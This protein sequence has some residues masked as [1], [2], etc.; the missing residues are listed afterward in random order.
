[1]NGVDENLTFK[2]YFTTLF[3][4]VSHKFIYIKENKTYVE[5]ESCIGYCQDKDM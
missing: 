4:N 3:Q 1:M 5:F 2:K